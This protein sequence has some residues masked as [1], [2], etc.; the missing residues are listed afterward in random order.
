M[1]KLLFKDRFAEEEWACIPAALRY[2][3]EEFCALSLSVG[4]IP[5]CTRVLR[6]VPGES[7]VHQDNRAVDFRDE[8]GVGGTRLYTP[9]QVDLIVNTINAKFPRDDKKL[10]VIHHAFVNHS[11]TASARAPFHFHIQIPFSWKKDSRSF[12]KV[13]EPDSIQAQEPPA[14]LSD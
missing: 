9:V 5:T 14:V 6:K 1:A 11:E 13:H 3:C 7:G 2:I 4:V 12:F 10:V 8:M